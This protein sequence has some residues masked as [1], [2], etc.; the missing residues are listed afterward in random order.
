MSNASPA[1]RAAAEASC[2]PPLDLAASWLNLAYD[3]LFRV[4]S[5]TESQWLMY[6]YIMTRHASVP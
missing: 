4:Q 3:Q 6:M 1:S 2:P 5:V